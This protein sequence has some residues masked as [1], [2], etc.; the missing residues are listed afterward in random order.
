MRLIH[1]ATLALAAAAS[2]AIPASAQPPFA[3]LGTPISEPYRAMFDRCDRTDT[4][5]TVHFPILNSAGHIR[6]F[7]CRP[8]PSRFS[9]FVA[10]PATGAALAAV[11]FAAKL[12]H[13]L[14]G[15]PV[16]CGG[17]HG[18]TDQCGTSLMLDPSAAHPCILPR[19]AHRQ[20]VPVNAAEIPYV[21][22]P[23]AAPPGI[24]GGEFRQRSG[25]GL[26][27]YGVVIANGRTIPVIVADVGPA[28][29]IGEGSTALLSALSSDGR[30]RTIAAGVTF[31]I[32]PGSRDPRAS[33]S[34]DTLARQ[35]RD[36][37]NALF[38]AF[39]LA[40]P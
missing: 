8:D 37:G 10:V 13:D 29:K 24:D 25:I 12:A 30:P 6:W 18:P 7:P 1:R 23:G 28:Y 26:G 33:L 17:A 36:R 21:V 34:P 38:R 11:I 35:V 27:D 14:D 32:F 39:A 9:R 5:G 2:L 31:L 16:A 40:H 3:G 4:F 19:T 22:L 15:S 20:C